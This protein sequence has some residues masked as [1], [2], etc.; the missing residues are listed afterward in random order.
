MRIGWMAE[1]FAGLVPQ[2]N[3]LDE[4]GRVAGGR[5]RFTGR[6]QREIANGRW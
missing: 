1:H 3:A 6:G 4:S 5:L 2:Q